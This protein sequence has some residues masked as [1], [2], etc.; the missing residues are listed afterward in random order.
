[1]CLEVTNDSF[2]KLKSFKQRYGWKEFFI[3]D[4]ISKDVFFKYHAFRD[5]HKVPRSKWLITKTK[6]NSKS[7]SD[8][9]TGKL[10]QYQ[11]GFHIFLKRPD[12]EQDDNFVIKK[13]R[14]KSPIVTGEQFELPVVVAKQL[15]VR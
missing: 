6:E 1:M 9:K 8:I 13:V 5:S 2:E 14:W 7:T 12:F 11:L 10:V 4:G 3:T 15:F